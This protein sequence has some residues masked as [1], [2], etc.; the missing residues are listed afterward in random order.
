MNNRQ[1]EL[2]ARIQI[3]VSTGPHRLRQQQ[4]HGEDWSR[5]EGNKL[6]GTPR[7]N[8]RIEKQVNG[9]MVWQERP[10]DCHEKFK[11]SPRP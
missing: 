6:G 8:A 5:M 9:E 2:L 1:L 7:E 4:H 11:C 10:G 3:I